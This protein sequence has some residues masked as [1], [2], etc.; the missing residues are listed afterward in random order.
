MCSGICRYISGA[1]VHEL[2]RSHCGDNR[3]LPNTNTLGIKQYLLVSKSHNQ[4]F[5][6]A[7]HVKK[8]LLFR[9]QRVSEIMTAISY[10]KEDDPID[11]K[12][13]SLT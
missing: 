7:C 13:S 3:E 8:N 9:Y 4:I 6:R 11:G 1:Q 10:S 2:P 5:P 12:G